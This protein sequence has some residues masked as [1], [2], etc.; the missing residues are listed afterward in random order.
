MLPES[1]AKITI[2]KKISATSLDIDSQYYTFTLKSKMKVKIRV[3]VK[4]RPT[5]D[6][7]DYYYADENLIYFS[8]YY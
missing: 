8:L 5:E 7:E 3:M 1:E 6:E 4:E 2:G